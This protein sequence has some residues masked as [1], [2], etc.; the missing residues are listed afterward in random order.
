M[1]VGVVRSAACVHH[2]GSTAAPRPKTGSH[3]PIAGSHAHFLPSCVEAGM[4]D[5]CEWY[6][7]TVR[8]RSD[9]LGRCAASTLRS[10]RSLFLFRGKRSRTR[11]FSLPRTV[12]RLGRFY[13]AM[14][15]I[16]V[17]VSHQSS[18]TLLQH[19]RH[20]NMIHHNKALA[21]H[22]DSHQNLGEPRIFNFQVPYN[23]HSS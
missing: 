16:A 19:C 7:V 8:P 21:P 9:R 13:G 1:C 20:N 2:A 5:K 17:G 10:G 22:H 12:N 23:I 6:G 14:T 11:S 3:D 18:I 15:T 4:H